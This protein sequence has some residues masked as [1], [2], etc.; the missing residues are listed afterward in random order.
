MLVGQRVGSLFQH[1]IG[2]MDSH[3][4]WTQT[5]MTK[6]SSFASNIGTVYYCP[7]CFRKFATPLENSQILQSLASSYMATVECS[8]TFLTLHEKFLSL[9]ALLAANAVSRTHFQLRQLL[10]SRESSTLS[11]KSLH[12]A[13][14]KLLRT[15]WA[16]PGWSEKTPLTL[17]VSDF[18]NVESWSTPGVRDFL[19][20][21]LILQCQKFL[22]E[23]VTFNYMLNSS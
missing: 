9:S 17:N 12:F 14:R 2:V 1:C 23:A 6:L 4:S 18:H 16:L 11:R 20:H 22:Q 15:H 10:T 3:H 5:T 13:Q 21:Q 8:W 19:K 7:F